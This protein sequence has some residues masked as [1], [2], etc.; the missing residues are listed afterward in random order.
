V[1]Q[2][3]VMIG[4]RV[5]ISYSVD[6]VGLVS[7]GAAHDLSPQIPNCLTVVALV[8]KVLHRFFL[9]LIEGAYGGAY[10]T[11]FSEIVPSEDVVLDYEP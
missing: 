2:D 6:D 11:S 4:D 7:I 3:W 1:I 5:P 8:E 10:E 9:L